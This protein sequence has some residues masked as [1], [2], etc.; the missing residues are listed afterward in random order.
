MCI[1]HFP[2]RPARL[3]AA[4]RHF[5]LNALFKRDFIETR[6]QYMLYS[7]AGCGYGQI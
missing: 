4:A 6:R 5:R 7:K 3:P 2:R 1:A